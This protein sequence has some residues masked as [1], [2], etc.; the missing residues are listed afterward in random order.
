MDFTDMS[1]AVFQKIKDLVPDFA[2][3]SAKANFEEASVSAFQDV[4]GD[5]N[6]ASCWFHHAQSIVKHANKVG[7]TEAYTSNDDVS[8][9]VH[10]LV[11]LPLSP[12]SEISAAV[13][14]VQAQLNS[15]CPHASQTMDQQAHHWP[16]R[17][18]PITFLKAGIANR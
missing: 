8:S 5:I 3:T 11:S 17:V 2:P 10:C 4:F 14:D 7:L 15:T 6:V 18:A 12:P 16:G 9:I 13:S 1:S